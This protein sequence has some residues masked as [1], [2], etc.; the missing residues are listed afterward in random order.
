MKKAFWFVF[1]LLL[2]SIHI[3]AET[4]VRVAIYENHPLVFT[5]EDGRIDGLYID[6]LN[7]IAKQEGW[8]LI[9]VGGTFVECL[10]LLEQGWV[11]LMVA[12]AYTEERARRFD[13]NSQTV[14]TN[15]GRIYTREKSQISSLLDLQNTRIAYVEGDIYYQDL[16]N[17]LEKFGIETKFVLS[18]DYED[19]LEKIDRGEVDAGVVARFFGNIHENRFRVASTGIIFKPIELRFA[20]RK[21]GNGNLL[22][23]IDRNLEDMKANPNSV[24]HGSMNKWFNIAPM[25]IGQSDMKKVRLLTLLQYIMLGIVLV[26]L[27][28]IVFGRRQ[29][30]AKMKTLFERDKELESERLY[31]QQAE[32]ETFESQIRFEQIIEAM[33][34]GIVMI[35]IDGRIQYANRQFCSMIGVEHRDVHNHSLFDFCDEQRNP[36]VKKYILS[37]CEDLESKSYESILRTTNGRELTVMMSINPICDVNGVNQGFYAIVTDISEIREKQQELE[38]QKAYFEQLFENSPNAI[39]LVNDHDE[40]IAV[41]AGFTR[42]FQYERSECVGRKINSLIVPTEMHEDATATSRKVLNKQSIQKEST[43]MR[44]DGLRID[45]SILGYPIYLS[46]KQI[47]VFAIYSDISKK[48]I[49]EQELLE[50]RQRFKLIFEATPVALYLETI[51]GTIIECNQ[52][53]MT[54]TGF[55]REELQGMNASDLIPRDRMS[56]LGNYAQDVRSLGWFLTEFES[57]RKNGERFPVIVAGNLVRIGDEDRM[58]VAV[59]DISRRK[60]AEKALAAEKEHLSVMLSSIGDA[61]IATDIDGRITLINRIASELTGWPIDE[62]V[63]KPLSQIFNIVNETTRNRMEDPVTQVLR[64][65]KIVQLP[66]QTLLISAD[67]SERLIAENGA[68]I[69]DHEGNTI[70]IVLVFRDITDKHYIEREITKIQKLE[71]LTL[72]AGGIAHDFNNILTAIIG[73]ISLAKI[74]AKD[75]PQ[76]NEKI[77]NAE[78]AAL[79]ARDLTH[80]LLTFSRGGDLIKQST[81]LRNIVRETVSFV[82]SG[83]NVRSEM[84]FDEGLPQVNVDP[85]QINQVINNLVINALQAMKD[86]GILRV[87][88]ANVTVKQ[89]QI[90]SLDPGSYVRLSIEDNGPGIPQDIQDKIFDPYFTTKDEGNGLGLAMT[91]SIIKRHHG[92]ILLDSHPGEGAR[93]DIY[94]PVTDG[95][96]AS[97]DF[98]M[99]NYHGNYEKI[100]VM[101]DDSIVQDSL[102]NFLEFLGYEVDFADHGEIAIE[103]YRKSLDDEKPYAAVI[104]DLTV[105]GA[106]GGKEC[107]RRLLEI[108]P[109]VRAIASSGYSSDLTIDH[110]GQYGFLDVVPKPYKIEEIGSVLKRVI[111]I[112]KSKEN[113]VVDS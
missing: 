48:K 35:R 80:Q 100:L 4:I 32:K 59:Q 85:G 25:A 70:G 91:Y 89:D 13:Y 96:S 101:D 55:T 14:L 26:A 69:R 107:I 18:E 78:K 45:V 104:L 31:R 15:W 57:I 5:G 38:I 6:V 99:Q 97:K 36:D 16:K 103:K 17:T 58:I 43:R 12:I 19:I 73:N 98:I 61:V 23:L 7:E 92:H 95:I 72:L 66:E 74:Y 76:A 33:N 113:S 90:V 71:T 44:K 93:F 79:Q 52:V 84:N 46:D 29:I 54:M 105:P 75:L 87:S 24:Y 27:V 11:E 81:D 65:G 50:S 109:D 28:V 62:A 67:G 2:F 30:R 40:I 21:G 64:S 47:G 106:M 77:A 63:G 60:Q 51:S 112:Q 94:L 3:S 39:A 22:S 88:A 102:G 82:L 41:N 53:A 1:A 108:D 8:S 10:D 34:E 111:G 37:H 49:V 20:T 83:S 56:E 42:L 110:Y 68:P 9:F 86:G